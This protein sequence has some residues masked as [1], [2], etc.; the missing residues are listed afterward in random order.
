MY[1]RF[2]EDS[3]TISDTLFGKLEIH[4][5]TKFKMKTTSKCLD[6]DASGQELHCRAIKKDPLPGRAAALIW[7]AVAVAVLSFIP[8]ASAQIT[9]TF[10]N[11]DGSP[12]QVEPGMTVDVPVSVAN[13][14]DVS[15]MQFTLTWDPAVVQYVSASVADTTFAGTQFGD[16]G[17]G[18]LTVLWDDPLNIGPVSASG[19]VFTIRLSVAPSI[20]VGSQSDLNFTDD[21]TPRHL[22][23]AAVQDIAGVQWHGGS[24]SVVPEP[25]AGA[26]TLGIVCLVLGIAT[27]RLRHP[28][29]VDWA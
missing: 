27:R 22:Y 28:A 16:V 13:L 20:T 4:R 23:D 26:A 3:R 7:S 29:R 9:L 8:A 24:I 10:G 14:S 25:A 12:I 11:S 21:P 18:K 2:Y 15:S 19:D 17:G 6:H 1:L 5:R